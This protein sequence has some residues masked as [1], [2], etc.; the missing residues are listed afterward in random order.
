M[1]LQSAILRI[2]ALFGLPAARFH[3]PFIVFRP[4]ECLLFWVFAGS[5]CP[6]HEQS[7]PDGGGPRGAIMAEL[8]W[9]D[10]CCI[11]FN[12]IAYSLR[13]ACLCVR[14]MKNCSS[15][16]RGVFLRRRAFT[17]IEVVL[18]AA[19][20]VFV[21]AAILKCYTIASRRS[22]YASCSLSANLEAMK[23]LE[24]VINATWKYTAGGTNIFIP[25][26]TNNDPENLEMPVSGATNLINCTNYTTV[27][28]VSTNPPYV[29]IT[30]KCVW[31]YNGLGN[32]TNTIACIRGPDL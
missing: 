18:A 12:R 25:S 10:I 26:L 22:F 20:A 11:K 13:G 28:Q 16:R 9:Q 5:P 23:K 15:V 14:F 27:T 3:S 1:K 21:C 29:M 8:T 6:V 7:C 24:N 4:A 2:Q 19:I 31:Y 17:L 30:V 32:F